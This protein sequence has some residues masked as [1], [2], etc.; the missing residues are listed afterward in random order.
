MNIGVIEAE[1]I[2]RERAEQIES[3]R[4]RTR[5]LHLITNFEIGGTER[6][7]VELLKRLNRDRFDVRLGRAAQRRPVMQ[8]D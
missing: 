6:Q 1:T 4:R 7:A 3:A 8:R 5:V 2:G